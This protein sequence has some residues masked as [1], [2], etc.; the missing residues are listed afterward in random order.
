MSTVL[1]VGHASD[2][3]S[4]P[5]D[6]PTCGIPQVAIKKEAPDEPEIITEVRENPIVVILLIVALVLFALF[7]LLMWIRT[8]RQGG[9]MSKGRCPR[10][11]PLDDSA[12]EKIIMINGGGD[13]HGDGDRSGTD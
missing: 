9:F 3:P 2:R 13:V 4:I 6:F 1:V 5:K 12:G 8:R 7:F 11:Q 10:R